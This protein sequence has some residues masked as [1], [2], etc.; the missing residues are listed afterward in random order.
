MT[1]RVDE[2]IEVLKELPED[3]Q[4]TV[5]NAILDYASHDDGRYH[6]SD[7]ERD[8]VRAGLAEVRMGKLATHADVAR[9]Y[10]HIGL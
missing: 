4:E 8:E 7:F 3:Q 5:A 2:A 10:K 6:L 9:V 1:K